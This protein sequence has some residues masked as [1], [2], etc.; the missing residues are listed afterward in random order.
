MVA[1]K[2]ASCMMSLPCCLFC[3]H[4]EFS[5]NFHYCIAVIIPMS[6][7]LIA[8]SDLE[9][10]IVFLLARSTVLSSLHIREESLF[11]GIPTNLLTREECKELVLLI[12]SSVIKWWAFLVIDPTVHNQI[13]SW[14]RLNVFLPHWNQSSSYP[15]LSH[16]STGRCSNNGLPGRK[17][18]AVLNTRRSTKC[19]CCASFTFNPILKTLV[20]QDHL[21]G[22]YPI[23]LSVCLWVLSIWRIRPTH[24]EVFRAQWKL[25]QD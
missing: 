20:F 12:C 18:P 17:S 15:N 14:V 11:T 23:I 8:V 22:R 4:N 7:P 25:V 1:C 3:K 10:R 21:P 24:F 2:L 5:S 13:V 9:V 16:L 6:L 19:N